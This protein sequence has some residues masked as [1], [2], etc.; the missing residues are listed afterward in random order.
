MEGMYPDFIAEV[1]AP[2]G[3]TKCSCPVYSERRLGRILSANGMFCSL[4]K[5]DKNRYFFC[6]TGTC[7]RIKK[8]SPIFTEELSFVLF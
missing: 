7:N 1:S 8:N 6:K 4:F 2:D 3:P 5:E